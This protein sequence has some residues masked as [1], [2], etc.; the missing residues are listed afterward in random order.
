MGECFCSTINHTHGIVLHDSEQSSAACLSSALRYAMFR[1]IATPTPCY[2]AAA[3]LREVFRTTAPAVSGCLALGGCWGVRDQWVDRGE[4][5]GVGSCGHAQGGVDLGKRLGD[6]CWLCRGVGSCGLL[7][8]LVFWSST[9]EAPELPCSRCCTAPQAPRLRLP[10]SVVANIMPQLR[11]KQPRR[12][13]DAVYGHFFADP[14]GCKSLGRRSFDGS[15]GAG[16]GGQ[17]LMA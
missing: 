9:Q 8:P 5:W 14:S 4:R 10:A 7:V 16:G 3:A 6:G 2:R 17:G 15:D 11:R 12:G 1:L 13:P